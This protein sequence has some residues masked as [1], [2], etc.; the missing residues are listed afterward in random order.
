MMI[1]ILIFIVAAIEE[2]TY[3]KWQSDE[4]AIVLLYADW[5]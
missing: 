5:W 4:D 3:E 1:S 2:V